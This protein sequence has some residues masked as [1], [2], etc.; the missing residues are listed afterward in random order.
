LRQMVIGSCRREAST[1]PSVVV[2]RA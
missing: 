2:V 1:G